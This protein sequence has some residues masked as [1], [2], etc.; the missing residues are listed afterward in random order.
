MRWSLCWNRKGREFV[1]ESVKEYSLTWITNAT[2]K[3]THSFP[4]PFTFI[5]LYQQTIHSSPLSAITTF[6]NIIQAP[7]QILQRRSI[8]SSKSLDLLHDLHTFNDSSEHNVTTVQP[9]C[10]HLP[11]NRIMGGSTV[12]MKNWDPFEFGP[13]LTIESKPGPTCFIL[14]FSLGI[15]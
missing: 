11:M 3:E 2:S 13:E 9:L 6:L 4:F 15:L 1:G 12:V 8:A 14:K 7:M 5:H 10:F